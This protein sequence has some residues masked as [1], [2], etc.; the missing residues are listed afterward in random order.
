MPEYVKKQ[1]AAM[2]ALAEK[3]REEGENDYVHAAER[4]G[5]AR[6]WD[7]GARAMR[8]RRAEAARLLKKG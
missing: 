8:K 2:Q 1:I 4:F 3:M 7:S 6:T 5:I